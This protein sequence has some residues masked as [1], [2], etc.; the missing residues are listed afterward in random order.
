MK[1][2]HQAWNNHQHEL[3]G[4]LRGRVTDAQTADDL[5]QDVFVKALA[6]RKTFCQL[7]NTRAWLYRVAKNRLI[8]FQRSYKYHAEV[9]DCLPDRT[10]EPSPLSSL[11]KCLPPTFKFLP[12]EDQEII[13]LCDLE[14][15]HQAEYARL[16]GLSV[17]ATKSRVQRA[18]KRLKNR[19]ITSCQINFDNRGSVCCFIPNA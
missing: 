14:G 7:E 4:F 6:D 18:R 12:R 1:C 13:K 2:I 16:K 17:A 8:D 19:L 9:T 3:R 11:S 10:H 15:M 5:L